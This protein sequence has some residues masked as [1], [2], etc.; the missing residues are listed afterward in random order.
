MAL[1]ILTIIQVGLVSF[2]QAFQIPALTAAHPATALL[3]FGA[4]VMAALRASRA[5][6]RPTASL[7]AYQPRV[8]A[9]AVS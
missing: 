2:F 5:L 9:D 3:L 4:A 7:T 1:L 6:R 8:P